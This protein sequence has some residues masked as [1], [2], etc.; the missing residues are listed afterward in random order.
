MTYLQNSTQNSRSPTAATF[1][2][3]QSGYVSPSQS[4]NY[5]ASGY[6][7]PREL[8]EEKWRQEAEQAAKP[9]KVEMRGIYKELGGRKSKTKTKLGSSGG[10]RD[11][12]GWAEATEEW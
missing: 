12:G 9:G 7:T 4:N 11:K 5:S 1:S 3:S 10:V 8:K 2:R 6:Q